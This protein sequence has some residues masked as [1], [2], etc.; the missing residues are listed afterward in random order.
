MKVGDLVKIQVFKGDPTIT[1]ALVLMIDLD[2]VKV[3]FSNQSSNQ[4]ITWLHKEHLKVI[5]HG[6]QETLEKIE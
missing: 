3:A 5:S 6:K 1:R 4:V 2:F